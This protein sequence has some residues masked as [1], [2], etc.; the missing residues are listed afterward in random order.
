MLVMQETLATIYKLEKLSDTERFDKAVTEEI[1]FLY[2][3]ELTRSQIQKLIL[4]GNLQVD[5]RVYNNKTEHPKNYQIIELSIIHEK[6][7]I[8]P[9]KIDLN[10][11]Y[12]D[13][14]LLIINKPAGLVVHPGS[15]NRSGT[16][17]NGLV[18]YLGEE[19][20]LIGDKLRPGIVHR[21]DK[22]TSGLMMVAKNNHSY[23][24]LTKQF[25]PPKTVSRKYLALVNG[26]VKND[27]DIINKPLGRDP[28]SRVKIAVVKNGR[29]A[30]TKYKVLQ[31]FNSS[32]LLELELE[33]GRTHQIRVHLNSIG[34]PV[35][36]DPLYGAKTITR[37][38]S[39]LFENIPGQLLHAYKLS[40][41]HPT[42]KE[43]VEY[44]TDAPEYFTS[45]VNHLENNQ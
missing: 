33:T 19:L 42:N 9:E 12:E 27:E 39:K 15:G 24:E 16:L 26:T 5:G 17:L 3:L 1:N 40:F 41:L 13:L 31:R 36:N 8:I 32:T 38:L 23:L 6:T 7:D 29:E 30:I 37:S 25:L 35:M 20:K 10:I 14:D 2:D 4:S 22:D 11:V 18:Y 45:L 44:I 21:L 34:Y 43:R 28:K